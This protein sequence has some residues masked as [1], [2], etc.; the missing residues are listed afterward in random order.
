MLLPFSCVDLDSGKLAKMINNVLSSWT[1]TC[2]AHYCVSFLAV[3]VKLQ[4]VDV[5]L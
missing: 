1:Q 5:F 3:E 4:T 2:Q